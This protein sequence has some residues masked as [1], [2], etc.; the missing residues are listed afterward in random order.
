L[1][2]TALR[3]SRGLAQS[4]EAVKLVFE[5]AIPNIDG[6]RIVALVEAYPPGGKIDA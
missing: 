1:A 3:V 6:K 4:S 5:H 2:A